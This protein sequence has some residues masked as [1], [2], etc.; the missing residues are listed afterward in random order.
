[1][2]TATTITRFQPL[3]SCCDVPC[4]TPRLHRQKRRCCMCGGRV[5]VLLV[6][7]FC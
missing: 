1:L 2:A 5:R 7:R 6:V 3:P 4:P